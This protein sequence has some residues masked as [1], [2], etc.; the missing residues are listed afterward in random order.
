MK[1]LLFI[2]S[3]CYSFCGAQTL[4][5]PYISSPTV[6]PQSPTSSQIIKIVIKVTTPNQGIVVDQST[7]SVTQNPKEIKIRGCYWNGMLT[8][9]QDYV[10]TLIIGQ[11]PAGTYTIKHK[12][13]LSST[14]QHCSATD[15]NMV[16]T[17]LTVATVTAL[18]E[19]EQ[20]EQVLIHPVPASAVIHVLNASAYSQADI[21]SYDGRLLKT[22]KPADSSEVDI[23]GFAQGMYFIYF[24][25][26]QKHTLTKFIKE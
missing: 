14:Q 25:G 1:K 3:L 5:L 17:T 20:N 8:A 19:F 6:I 16:V 2:L 24:S 11:L 9:T 12:A 4:S 15:S 21:Y 22:I 18:K 26:P 13:F 7:F 10:D 23:S